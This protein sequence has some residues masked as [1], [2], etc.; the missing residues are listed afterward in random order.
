MGGWNRRSWDL[1]KLRELIRENYTHEQIARE[2]DCSSQQVSRLCKKHQIKCHRTGPRS[3]P[4]H[5]NWKGGRNL[6]KNGYVLLYM[7]EHPYAGTFRKS[8]V[9]EHRLVMEK[10]L[11]RYLVPSEVVHHINGV[12]TD[13]RIENLQLFDKNSEHLRHELTG[14]VPKWSEE[15]KARFLLAHQKWC[16]SRRALKQRGSLKT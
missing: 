16:E 13:N 5:P 7:P 10:H 9:R 12:R 2:F 8:Y 11:G 3:G 4:G 1:D 6:D 14:K 15:G